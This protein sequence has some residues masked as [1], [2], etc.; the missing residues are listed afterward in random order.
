MNKKAEFIPDELFKET[1]IE[2]TLAK[3]EDLQIPV[4]AAKMQTEQISHAGTLNYLFV[5]G[6]DFL[7]KLSFTINDARSGKTLTSLFVEKDAATS[8]SYLKI[9]VSDEKVVE[10]AF[11][12]LGGLL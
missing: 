7:Q 4:Q 2:E 9:P 12:A 5:I 1:G 6:I 8:K 10:Q 3:P 11:S